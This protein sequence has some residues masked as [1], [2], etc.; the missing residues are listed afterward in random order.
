L[1]RLRRQNLR[2]NRSSVSY[3]NQNHQPIPYCIPS[4]CAEAAAAAGSSA[5]PP[6]G[7]VC[8]S[9]PASTK[10]PT[11]VTKLSRSARSSTY[12]SFITCEDSTTC[13]DR[14]TKTLFA[15]PTIYL[16]HRSVRPLPDDATAVGTPHPIINFPYEAL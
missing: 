6:R 7:V 8:P 9:A 4:T 15:E 5:A 14:T 10:A 2:S 13:H 3:K 1:C 12:S 11:R 16:R